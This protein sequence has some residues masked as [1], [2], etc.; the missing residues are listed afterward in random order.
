MVCPGSGLAPFRAFLQHRAEQLRRSPSISL[1]P[2]LLLI[3]CRSP[4]HE[5]Y[6]SELNIW[7]DNG[8][9][10]LRYAYSRH[11]TGTDSSSLRGYVQDRAWTDREELV[12][13]WERGAKVYVCGGNTV[14][15][16][17]KEVVRNIYRECAAKLC[18]RKTE[19]EVEEWWVEILRERYAVNVF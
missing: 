6:A 7:Q 18:G 12:Q 9:V 13:L 5:I 16:G 10:Q 3:G 15:Q 4:L 14:S 11:G 2:A 1:A 8:V 19:S 17:V